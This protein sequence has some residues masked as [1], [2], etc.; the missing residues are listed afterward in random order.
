VS[1]GPNATTP[2][3]R[4]SDDYLTLVDRFRDCA[5]YLAVNVSSPNT[6]GLRDLEGAPLEDLLGAV[7]ERAAATPVLV[8]LSPDLADPEEAARAAERAGAAGIIVGNTTL[9]RPGFAG[10]T[11]AGG[12]SGAPLSSLALERL[13][14]VTAATRLPVIACGGIMTAA[15]AETRFDA[16]AAL[17]QVY[18]GLV[19]RG[20]SLVRQI[21]RSQPDG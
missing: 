7:H 19:Y 13:W 8:K 9:S 3:E 10:E 17:V 12:L 2:P 14:R 18:T 6:A 21:T 20:T 1:I 4:R 5:D 15:D 16:G 11:P